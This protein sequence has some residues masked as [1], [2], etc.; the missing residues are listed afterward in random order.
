MAGF[1]LIGGVDWASP[2]S[3]DMRKLREEV[4]IVEQQ[5]PPNEEFD[6]IDLVAYHVLIIDDAGKS[7]AT[8]RLYNHDDGS[9]GR[10]G[11]MAVAKQAR[12]QGVGRMVLRALMA[13]G[14][15]RRYQR[16]ILDAQVQA[17]PFYENSGFI[18]YG[19]EHLDCGIPHR[20]MEITSSQAAKILAQ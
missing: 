1:H 2:E 10:I 18:V 3:H 6:E 11:R 19:E 7:V 4:F 12:G 8:G 5:V 16:M 14:I 15:R 20:M 9:V 13:E 17:I